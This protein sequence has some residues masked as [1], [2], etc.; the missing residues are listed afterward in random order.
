LW[1][2]SAHAKLLQR[3]PAQKISQQLAALLHDTGDEIINIMTA[4]DK[5][6]AACRVMC[7]HSRAHPGVEFLDAVLVARPVATLSQLLVWLQ[8]GIALL[9]LP[10]L[11]AELGR[12]AASG[13]AA[14]TDDGSTTSSSSSSS[15]S[16]I[17]T[18]EIAAAS[19]ADV[20]SSSSDGGGYGQLWW[21]CTSGNL[22]VRLTVGNSYLALVLCCPNLYQIVCCLLTVQLPGRCN[23]GCFGMLTRSRP[24]H[25]STHSAV[26]ISVAQDDVQVMHGSVLHTMLEL[27]CVRLSTC[28]HF[29]AA[30]AC[31]FAGLMVALDYALCL[32]G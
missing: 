2:Q 29:V 12:R 3:P 18:A 32:Q 4:I 15:S 14:A 17:A 23:D 7:N 21:F 1:K 25:R 9:Q 11:A 13:A 20:S 6:A 27:L 31:A 8:Q 16:S 24:S 28:S 30:C 26:D 22:P 5:A 19:A 10:E